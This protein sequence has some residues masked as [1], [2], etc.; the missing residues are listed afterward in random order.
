[1]MSMTG[2]R[3]LRPV[4]GALA[5]L[6][7]LVAGPFFAGS[8]LAQQ[9]VVQGNRRV[10]TETI[11]SYVTGTATGSNEE[12]RQN[13]I[14][15]GLFSDVRISG[16]RNGTTTVVVRE[17]NVINR[18]FFE[19]NKKIEKGTLEAETEVKGRQA[20]N[21]AAAEADVGRIRDLY[22]RFGRAAAKV[23]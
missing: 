9:V 12:A 5:A 19:G 13:L 23:S 17:K 10:D 20:F 6:A 18:V 8:A 14:A 21:P 22:R 7:L 4:K 16:S 11:R 1:M 3:R 2:M 15:S